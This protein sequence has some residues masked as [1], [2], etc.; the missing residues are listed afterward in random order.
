MASWLK[1][2]A[3]IFSALIV[4]V[5]AAQGLFV[6]LTS[7]FPHIVVLAIASGMGAGS[8]ALLVLGLMLPSEE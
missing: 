2:V 4:V 5:L 3:I 7:I 6:V 8:V 1:S